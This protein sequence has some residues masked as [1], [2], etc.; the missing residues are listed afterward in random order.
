MPGYS[1]SCVGRPKDYPLAW[2]FTRKTHRSQKW[3]VTLRGHI[4]NAAKEKGAWDEI[5]EK[6]STSFQVSSLSGIA[7]MCLIFPAMCY[8]M[9]KVLLTGEVSSPEPWCWVFI[10]GQSCRHAGP[11]GAIYYSD[12]RP[13]STSSLSTFTK[14]GVYHKL[15]CQSKPV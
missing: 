3:F 6:P 2:W 11:A 7:W 4:L 8:N 12:S 14:T 15:H 9:C 10:G 5:Q 1:S 13:P